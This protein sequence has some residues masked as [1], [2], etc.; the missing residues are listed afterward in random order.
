MLKSVLSLLSFLLTAAAVVASRKTTNSNLPTFEQCDIDNSHRIDNKEWIL[1]SHGIKNIPSFQEMDMN[2]DHSIAKEEYLTYLKVAYEDFKGDSSN[3]NSADED[4][5][6]TVT[7]KMKDGTIKKMLKDDLMKEMKDR[8]DGFRKTKEN[9]IIKEENSKISMNNIEKENPGL[10]KMIKLGNSSFEILKYMNHTNGKLVRIQ[11]LKDPEIKKQLKEEEEEAEEEKK[12][13]GSQ[14]KE[15]EDEV[16]EDT[17]INY[18]KSKIQS[19]DGLMVSGVS[20]LFL[21]P[22]LHF[23]FSFI[24]N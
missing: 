17:I 18:H 3:E 10:N 24:L 14:S 21:Q 23:V 19:K 6:D 4:E 15:K 2:D 5:K 16:D 8:T 13:E 22:P 11:T 1:C 12:K 9:N 20:R 7:V